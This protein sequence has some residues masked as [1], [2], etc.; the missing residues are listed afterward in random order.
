MKKTDYEVNPLFDIVFSPVIIWVVWL[1]AAYSFRFIADLFTG[2]QTTISQLSVGG[3][4]VFGVLA[5]IWHAWV[6]RKK[7]FVAASFMAAIEWPILTTVAV[8]L[9]LAYIWSVPHEQTLMMLKF[10]KGGEFG[11]LVLVSA[12]GPIVFGLLFG[13]A[14]YFRSQ[15]AMPQP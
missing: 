12:F 13:L 6:W 1:F 5:S 2:I 11:P 15:R 8:Y 3:D 14:R 4:V 10:W 7:A 9:H